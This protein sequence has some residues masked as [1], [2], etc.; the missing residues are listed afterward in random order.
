MPQLQVLVFRT[1][2]DTFE[3]WM[4]DYSNVRTLMFTAESQE[5]LTMV[6][7]ALLGFYRRRVIS[8]D[9]PA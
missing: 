7:N 8:W 9:D 6:S 5:A 2:T 4:E 1:V 3:L